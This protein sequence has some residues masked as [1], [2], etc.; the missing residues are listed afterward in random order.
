MRVAVVEHSVPLSGLTSKL[1]FLYQ[2]RKLDEKADERVSKRFCRTKKVSPG[3][4]SL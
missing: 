1:R 4:V 2:E 3:A